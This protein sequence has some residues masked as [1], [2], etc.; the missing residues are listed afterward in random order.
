MA[1]S[2]SHY[3]ACHDCD[4]IQ[5][6]VALP[7]GASAA[8]ARCGAVLYKRKTNSLDRT[9][10]LSVAGVILFVVANAFPFL[11]FELKGQ[12]TQTTLSTGVRELYDADM[13]GLAFLVFLTTI[14]APMLELAGMLFI[15]GP[16]RLGWRRPY[17][18]PLFRL[19]RQLQPWSMMEVFMLGILVS[20]VKLGAMAEIVPGV[21]L[22]AFALMILVVAAAAA[23]LDAEDIWQRI[24][25]EPQTV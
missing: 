24:D 11:A 17:M 20:I 2:L 10:A 1:M 19:T 18:R 25:A 15:L 23:T 16:L 5:R 3:I 4:L 12:I 6:R 9:L 22:W 21:A 13:T 8:C 14:L 7:R